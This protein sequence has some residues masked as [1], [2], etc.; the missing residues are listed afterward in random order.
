MAMSR[1]SF[2]SRSA[3]AV[4]ASLLP[5]GLSGC[6]GGSSSPG[7]ESAGLSLGTRLDG[8]DI[9]R[10]EVLQWE[11][12]RLQVVAHRMSRNLPAAL[13]GELSALLLRPELSTADIAQ[14]RIALAQAKLRAGEAALRQLLAGD[15]A[16]TGA[17]SE[18]A[19][20]APLGW[21]V[22]EISIL[23]NRGSAEGFGRWFTGKAFR[24]DPYAML[25]ACPDHFVIR[26]SPPRGQEV[27]EITGGATQASHFSI[28][29]DNP[30]DLPLVIDPEFPVRFSGAAVNDK[31]TVI[32]GTNH[33]FRTLAEG[34]ES[35]LAIFFPAALPAWM[36]SE[37]RWHLACEF[38]NW[39]SAYIEET[40]D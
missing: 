4:A 26:P 11:A 24:D 5:A 33:R 12:R 20:A 7:G 10:E 13:L 37:H 27:I 29:Y 30:A 14:E 9:S 38:S 2:V 34:F 39:I 40:G 17:I 23:S 19:V 28:D 8:R 1:R 6:G 21:T 18:L 31:G 25:L 3:M 16:I 22:S 35:H 32:G 36:I 15:L